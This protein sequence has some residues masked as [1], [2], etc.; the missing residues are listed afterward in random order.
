M[1]TSKP[2]IKQAFQ[3]LTLFLREILR[4]PTHMGAIAP[5]SKRLAKAMASTVDAPD[6]QHYVVELGG[7]T[8]VITEALLKRVPIHQLIVVERAP[9][10]VAHLKERFLGL[11]VIEGDAT[12]LPDLL[13]D[14]LSRVSTIVSGLPILSFPK[15]VI[16]DMH[17]MIK[18][19]PSQQQLKW[20][21][22]TYRPLKKHPLAHNPR[23]QK[24]NS[25][26]VLFNLPPAWVEVY[27]ITRA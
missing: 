17:L 26:S 5:S 11:N 23:F 27:C 22:F 14:K 9:A 12:Q 18:A 1:T 24:A 8:G 13:G 15:P 7:G 4:S 2:P 16:D 19:L 20:V 3:G 6:N 10:L 21:Q 25:K